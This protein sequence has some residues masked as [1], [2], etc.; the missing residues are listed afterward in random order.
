M[1]VL[2]HGDLC[3]E[4]HI[5]FLS[6]DVKVL[7][8]VGLSADQKVVMPCK[9]RAIGKGIVPGGVH[10][11]PL[12]VNKDHVP[13]VVDVFALRIGQGIPKCSI[14]PINTSV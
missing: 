5:V 1:I 7:V 11:E 2:R 13:D 14:S 6:L 8:L 9:T 3:T 10:M 12:A 4:D